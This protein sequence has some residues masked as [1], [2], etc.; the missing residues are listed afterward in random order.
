MMKKVVLLTG[1]A[2]FAA[3]FAYS[4]CT[5]WVQPSPTTAWPDF[6]NQFGGAPCTEN[7][8]LTFEITAFEVWQSE[9]YAISNVKAGAS[10]TVG[11]CNGPDGTPSNSW[12]KSYTVISPSGNIDAFG[13]DAGSSCELTF[14]ATETGDYIIAVNRAGSSNCGV[15]SNSDGGYFSLT[16][17]GGGS[18]DP[19][20][21][22]CDAGLL[23]AAETAAELCPGDSTEF[24]IVGVVVP[25][26]PSI[27][28]LGI[29]VAPVPG[30]GSGGT[31]FAFS[32]TGIS[33][34]E[35]PYS[36]DNDLGG[37]LSFNGLDPL[38]GEWTFRPYVYDD[39]T[40]NTVA[41]DSTDSVVTVDFLSSGSPSCGELVCEAGDVTA[42]D[43]Q[44][45]PG[46][47]WE[48]TLSDEILPVPG[49]VF[50]F[51]IDT[52][53]TSGENDY[54]YNLGSDPAFYNFTGDFNGLL[55]G[56]D[57]D[58]LIPGTYLTFAG[59]FNPQDT[60]VCAFTPG[61]FIIDVLDGNDVEC[62]GEVPC[63][64]PYPEVTGKNETFQSNGVLLS[65]NPIPGSQGCEVQGSRADGAGSRKFRILGENI[66][67]RF[68]PQ[69]LLTPGTTYRWRVRCG[70]STSV[71]GP[72][73]EYR[74]FLWDPSSNMVVQTEGPVPARAADASEELLGM[75]SKSASDNTVFRN[76][77]SANGLFGNVPRIAEVEN[78]RILKD[79]YTKPLKTAGLLSEGF[80]VFPNPSSGI[81]NVRY[82]ASGRSLVTVRIF[83]ASGR[84]VD[85]NSLSMHAGENFNDLDLSAFDE[86]M[87]L[88]EITEGSKRSVQRLAITK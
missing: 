4:Q 72:Y 49:S 32:L 46:E 55:A 5:E 7:P 71:A 40:A 61:D 15:F 27:G 43:Q 80:D 68:V 58:T 81:V 52:N 31:G 87:Y 30:S 9:A 47:D 29:R 35:L 63:E 73:T 10:Y 56:A 62:G 21:T 86:G 16:Y 22:G 79:R 6:N 1:A 41:C 28:G 65:W 33:P 59:V 12:F 14:T 34:D 2:V 24:D 53:D 26:S 3:S 78:A 39:P 36:F 11:A 77:L 76:I 85:S 44:I 20:I 82:E 83:D 60:A 48:L 37:V 75:S 67:E 18:C 38:L 70:C 23:D 69:S 25:N 8:P 84:I 13:R 88:I 17:N 66:S 57:L 64:S 54:I 19:A 50:W 74:F 42:G 45:C 51:F